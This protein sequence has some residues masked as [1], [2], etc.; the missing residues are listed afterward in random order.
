MLPGDGELLLI[1]VA[2]EANHFHPIEE[3]RLNRVEDVRRDDEHHIRQV[4]GDA[5]IVIA[6]GEVLFGIEH[7]EQGR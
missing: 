2:G 3:R 7:F 1:G 4:I 6:E 5:E